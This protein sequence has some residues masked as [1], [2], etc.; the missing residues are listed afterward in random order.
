MLDCIF[1]G[2]WRENCLQDLGGQKNMQD[3]DILG[4]LDGFLNVLNEI[5]EKVE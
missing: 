2:F 5:Q 1:T 3:A 4:K